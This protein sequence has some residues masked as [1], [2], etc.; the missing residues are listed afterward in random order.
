MI[1]VN[2][3]HL[4]ALARAVH[5]VRAGMTTSMQPKLLNHIQR[6]IDLLDECHKFICQQIIEPGLPMTQ[7][8]DK[9][10]EIGESI[11]SA[12]TKATD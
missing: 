12:N 11:G 3:S 7:V 9:V 1:T 5:F 10:I 4:R 8:P 6:D 2:D